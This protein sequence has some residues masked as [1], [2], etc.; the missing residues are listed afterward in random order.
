[1]CWILFKLLAQLFVVYMD[2]QTNHFVKYTQEISMQKKQFPFLA[3]LLSLLSCEKKPL[4]EPEIPLPVTTELKAGLPPSPQFINGYLY[5]SFRLIRYGWNY[6][7]NFTAAAYF[8]D[9][10]RNLMINFDH[11]FDQQEFLSNNKNTPNVTVGRV[12]VNGLGMGGTSTTSYWTSTQLDTAF[13]DTEPTWNIEGNKTFVPAVIKLRHPP[14]LLNT[15]FNF[16]LQISAGYTLDISSLISNYDSAGVL[17]HMNSAFPAIYK[18]CPPGVQTIVFSS[19]ELGNLKN[20]SSC[21][22]VL[23]G[24]NYSHQMIEDKLYVFESSAKLERSLTIK[25]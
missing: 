18:S 11:L 7:T 17:I 16:S 8:G 3:L 4:Q 12:S 10:S 1:M 21:N 25:Q 22:I 19:K 20:R 2:P 6:N 13:L 9:P 23:V 5:S 24:F 15:S 14:K